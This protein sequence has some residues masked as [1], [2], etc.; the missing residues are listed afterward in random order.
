M[1]G[2]Y[3]LRTNGVPAT[4]GGF[5]QLL[6]TT[7]GSATLDQTAAGGCLGGDKNVPSALKDLEIKYGELTGMPSELKNNE[8]IRPRKAGFGI[9]G[10]VSPLRR[11]FIY[12]GLD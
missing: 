5:L 2:L 1:L 9:E 6:T 3:A 10:E 11:D 4:D 12:G 7:R 8:R